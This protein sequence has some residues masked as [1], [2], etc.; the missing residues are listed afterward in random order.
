MEKANSN[1]KI[2]CSPLLQL[3]VTAIAV[4][5]EVYPSLFAEFLPLSP[6]KEQ[7]FNG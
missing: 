5:Y 2:A 3:L 4:V 7:F 6:E 1:P